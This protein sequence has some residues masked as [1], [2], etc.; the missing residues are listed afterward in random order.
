[1]AVMLEVENKLKAGSPL[2]T[3]KGVLDGFKSAV[4]EE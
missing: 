3:V 2:D 1:M 4:N